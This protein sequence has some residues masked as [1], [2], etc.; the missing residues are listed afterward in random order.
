MFSIYFSAFNLIKNNFPYETNL[1]KACAFAE[2]VVVALN[3]SEDGSLEALQ[4][5]AAECP[6]LKIIQTSFSYDDIRFDGAIKNAA[7]QATTQ[8]VKIQ[9][10]LDEYIPLSQ[11]DRWIQYGNKLLELNGIQCLLIPSIDLYGST[12]T[13]KAVSEIGNKFRMH[14]AGLYRGITRSA[15]VGDKI[16]TD[17]SDTTELIDANGDLVPSIRIAPIENHSPILSFSLKDFIYTVHEG[18]LSFEHRANINKNV[19]AKAWK[20][21]SGRDENTPTNPDSLKGVQ[22]VK[23]NLKLD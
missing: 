12:E 21:R 3:T 4:K 15:W 14:K 9:M 20:D 17:I 23:H 16:R 1:R 2:E 7:L 11:K 8:P 13:I 6:N 18:Y 22:V 19:W 10:D 5:I